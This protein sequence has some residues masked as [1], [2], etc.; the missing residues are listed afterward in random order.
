MAYSLDLRQKVMDACDRG[1]KTRPVAQW[2]GVSESWVRRLKQHRRERGTIEPLPPSGGVEP[3]LGEDDHDK[4]HA[5][6]KTQPDTTI[7]ALKEALG[8]DAS[9]VTVWRAAKL[10][11][12]RFRKSRSTPPNASGRMSSSGVTCGPTTPRRSTPNT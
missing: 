11:G 7:V 10:L 4:I 9:E 1:M 12:Y 8:T 6:F 3:I 5:H 2:F